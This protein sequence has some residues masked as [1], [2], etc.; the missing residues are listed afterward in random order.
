M[1][2]A[3]DIQGCQSSGSRIR[4]IGR[5][6]RGLIKGLI[7]ASQENEIILVANANSYDCREY[8]KRELSSK[9]CNVSYCNWF[10]V[11]TDSGESSHSSLHENTLSIIRAYTFARLNADIILITSFFEGW[12]D[13]C[14]I[15]IKKNFDLPPI[16][17]IVYDLIPFIYQDDY[18]NKIPEYKKFYLN[19]ISKFKELNGYLAISESARCEAIKYLDIDKDKIF[20]ISSACDIEVFNKRVK[21]VINQDKFILYTGAADVRKNLKRLI[22]AY[23][24]LSTSIIIKY[25]L[26]LAGCYHEAEIELINKWVAEYTIPKDLVIIKSNISDNEL[27][28]LYNSCDLFVFPSLHEGFGLPALEAMSCGAVVIGSELTSIPEVINEKEA[29]FNPLD[30]NEISKLIEK[31]L[32]DMTFR[33]KL[34]NNSFKRSAL[35]SWQKSAERSLSAFNQILSNSKKEILTP[36]AIQDYKKSIFHK[37]FIIIR[38]EISNYHDQEYINNYLIALS[39]VISLVDYETSQYQRLKYNN[40]DILQWKIEGPYDS[41]YSLAILNRE[42]ALAMEKNGI[43]TFLNSTE[44]PGDYVPNIDYISKNTKLYEIHN[45][46]IFNT[47]SYDIITSRNLYPPRVKD[48]KGRLKLLHSYGWEETEFPKEFTNDFNQY[49]DGITVMSSQVKKILID[50]GVNLPINVTGLGVDHI[51]RIKV[52]KKY[53]IDC[54][55]FKFLHISSCFPRK[56]INCLL[57]SYGNS[58]RSS[59]DVTLIIKTFPNPHNEVNKLLESYLKKDKDYPDVLLIEDDLSDSNLKSILLQSDVLVA[60][61]LG[62]GFGLPIAE[63]MFL[64]IPVI[65]TSWGGQLDFCNDKNSWLIDFNFCYAK[66]HFNLISSIWAEPDHKHLSQLLIEIYKSEDSIKQ[67]R[68]LLAKETI[69]SYFTWEKVA[70]RNII[71]ANNLLKNNL[72]KSKV[73]NIGWIGTWNSRCGIASYSKNLLCNFSDKV[74]IFAP[75]NQEYIQEDFGEVRRCWKLDNQI[76]QSLDNLFLEIIKEEITT[77]VIQFNYGFFDFTEFGILIEKLKSKKINIIIFLHST[78]DPINIEKKSLNSLKDKLTICDRIFVHTPTDLNRLKAIHLER[79]VSIF[80]HGILDYNE[81]YKNIK[82]QYKINYKKL[83]SKTYIIST[84]GFCL[85]NKGFPQLIEAIYLARNQGYSFNLNLHTAIYN[86]N[87][88]YYPHELQALITNLD[89]SQNVKIFTSY[90]PNKESLKLLSESDLIVF[91]YQ[92]TTESSS[93]AVRHG[94]ASGA[95]IAVTPISIFDDVN[96]M[97]EVLPGISSKSLSEGIISLYKKQFIKHMDGNQKEVINR[98]SRWIEHHQFS[99]LSLRLNSIIKSIE[100]NVDSN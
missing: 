11:Q 65:T 14:F 17:A 7:D 40:K 9:N 19:K 97:V 77:V 67:K 88:L 75:D 64:G 57:K 85:P 33:E 39:S 58:F 48:I 95:S 79:N 54:N 4:G 43:T 27:A 12:N 84:F 23:S 10:P 86:S 18:L 30:V 2:I 92:K 71:F 90:I 35:F 59:D 45:R 56:G 16:F 49:L 42:M 8:F 5:Y 53:R 73:S 63:A 20:N 28:S 24:L 72:S 76:D 37:F 44:G 34:V 13:G 82:N 94:I 46:S 25:K 96:S 69:K 60:P 38:K 1:R 3:I 47:K 32:T 22:H 99:N 50:N 36:Q 15:P 31:T 26:I 6:T 51:D 80:P 89:L 61:S 93:A 83:N 66:N 100:R 91:P 74:T 21:P 55:R 98:K 29:L 70:N 68:V 81:T 52:E 78:T 41:S 62:E 87:Y